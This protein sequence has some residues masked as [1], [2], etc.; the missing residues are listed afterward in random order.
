MFSNPPKNF[1]S[2]DDYII[3]KIR[4]R[5]IDFDLEQNK[6]PAEQD[7]QNQ[8]NNQAVENLFTPT[9][10]VEGKQVPTDPKE[11]IENIPRFVPK[12]RSLYSTL[13]S[14]ALLNR[15]GTYNEANKSDV[16]F[17]FENPI[18]TRFTY[19][20]TALNNNNGKVNATVQ[21]Q[22]SVDKMQQPLIQENLIPL[23]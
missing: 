2:W 11:L 4:P 20:V 3:S 6:D 23:D 8:Q 7:Q 9:V 22:D 10:P 12:V 15:F 13:S 18:N 17:Y 19:K 5:F 21:I 14:S 1:N 16:F